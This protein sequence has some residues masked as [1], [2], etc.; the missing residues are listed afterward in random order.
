VDAVEGV[1]RGLDTVDGHVVAVGFGKF[2]AEL[3]IPLAQMT[4]VGAEIE[5]NRCLG[6][7][8]APN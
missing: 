3:V 2:G 6:L 7:R 4:R 8:R 1:R 5:V